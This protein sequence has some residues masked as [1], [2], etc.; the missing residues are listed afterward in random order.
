M[1]INQFI[2]LKESRVGEGRV[3]LTPNAVSL[4]VKKRF[5]I[6][7]ESGAGILA[8]FTDEK[9]REAGANIFK[10]GSPFPSHS[11]I[12]R[13]KCPTA[14]RELSENK[15]LTSETIMMGF[16]DPL[17]EDTSHIDRWKSIGITLIPL[18]ILPLSADD[19]KNAQAAMSRFA[20]RLALQDALNHYQGNHPKKV[21]VIGTGPAGIE[22]AFTARN[23]QLPVQLFGRQER[24]RQKME[25]LGIIYYTLPETNARDFI[26]QHLNDQTIIITAARNVGENSP[27]LIDDKELSLLPSHSVIIDLATGEGGNVKGSKSD[28]IVITDR[29]IAIINVSGYPKA[30]PRE[31]SNNFAKCMVNLLS[32]I[33]TPSMKL[34]LGNSLAFLAQHKH[35]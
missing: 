3:A 14:E 10:F 5:P 21:T 15:L 27:I 13:V 6:S 20:G 24:F 12:L 1:K 7:V 9:Y 26:C 4:L 19:P 22:A 17:D 29:N 18:E 8:G 34:N 2:V 28:Q 33:I 25:E 23:L 16:L 32:E 11:F 35:M 30:E 31:A